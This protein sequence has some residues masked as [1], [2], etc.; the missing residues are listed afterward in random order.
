MPIIADKI[1]RKLFHLFENQDVSWKQPGSADYDRQKAEDALYHPIGPLTKDPRWSKEEWSS[2]SEPPD[3]YTPGGKAPRWT[4]TEIVLAY[5]GAPEL[6]GLKSSGNPRS[7]KY[8]TMGG[9]PM[10][11]LARKTAREANRGNDNGFVEEMFD[12]GLAKLS[13]L[14]LPGY[15]KSLSAFIPWV[16]ADIKYAMWNGIG[17]TKGTMAAKTAVTALK[18]ETDPAKIR[19]A[20]NRVK[21]KYQERRSPN[22]D[23]ENNPF[24]VHS[25]AFYQIA[26]AY[27]D[28][29]ETGDRDRILASK[30]KIEQLAEEIEKSQVSVRGATTGAGQAISTL[31]RVKVRKIRDEKGNVIRTERLNPVP[32]I[33]SMDTPADDGSTIAGNIT[34]RAEQTNFADPEVMRYLLARALEV[35]LNAVL[36]ADSKFR[37][38]AEDIYYAESEQ[39]GTNKGPELRAQAERLRAEVQRYEQ[40]AKELQA[41]SEKLFASSQ[42]IDTQKKAR[43]KAEAAKRKTA[44]AA[45]KAQKAIDSDAE[46]VHAENNKPKRKAGKVTLGG[47]MTVNEFRYIIRGLGPIAAEYPGRGEMRSA[48][49]I[50]RDARGWWKPM[51]DPEIEVIP[52][53]DKHPDGGK[54]TSIWARNGY[55]SMAR[56]PSSIAEEMTQEVREFDELGIASARS[57]KVRETGT[58]MDKVAVSTTAMKARIKLAIIRHIYKYDIGES[59]LRTFPIME[60]LSTVDRQ[61]VV[62]TCTWMINQLRLMDI[63][64]CTTTRTKQPVKKDKY[65]MRPVDAI[66]TEDIL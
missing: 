27:A 59:I 54:W 35:D 12:N 33:T 61:L 64:E 23:E 2:A 30:N 15:D 6:L 50:P 17:G 38:M 43:D 14:M 24:G 49:Q 26:M 8:G 3:G 20:A 39:K 40:S 10:Y 63:P 29:L 53:S 62:E 25:A 22:K 37:K 16:A 5:A 28:A 55:E 46:A 1:S 66:A 11:R 44:E 34:G 41:E 18:T 36:A 56:S 45:R 7:P 9:S 21:G 32:S 51:E 48:L 58:A 60:G 13:E 57:E 19:A 42:D 47:P 65:K 4:K 31:D 52:K